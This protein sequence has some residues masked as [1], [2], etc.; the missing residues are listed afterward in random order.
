MKKNDIKAKAAAKKKKK[1]KKVSYEPSEVAAG[2]GGG[3][4]LQGKQ[5]NEGA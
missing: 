4:N 1:K 2:F 5:K 3:K